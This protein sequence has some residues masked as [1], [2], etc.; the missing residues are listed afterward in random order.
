MPLEQGIPRTFM[1]LPKVGRLLSIREFPRE[2]SEEYS[3]AVIQWMGL[4]HPLT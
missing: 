2:L 4:S 1:I 3:G